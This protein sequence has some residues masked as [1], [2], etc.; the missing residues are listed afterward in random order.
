MNSENILWDPVYN[1]AISL[2]RVFAPFTRIADKTTRVDPEFQNVGSFGSES[3]P[4]GA[5]ELVSG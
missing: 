5:E 1:Q 3:A 4:P 2:N